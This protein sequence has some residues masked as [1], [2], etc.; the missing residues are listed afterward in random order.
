M[1]SKALKQ[2]RSQSVDTRIEA[3]NDILIGGGKLSPD[4]IVD[5]LASNPGFARTKGKTPV[6]CQT[7]TKRALKAELIPSVYR[8]IDD[9]PYR[10]EMVLADLYNRFYSN[11]ITDS[12]PKCFHERI[13]T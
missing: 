5:A 8:R 13:L 4:E 1:M 7:Y 12:Q 3:V 10:D 6:D 9:D 11:G 2:L